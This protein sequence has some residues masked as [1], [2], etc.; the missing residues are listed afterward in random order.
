[1]RFSLSTAGY[2]YPSA[3]DRERLGKLGFK[4]QPSD[5]KGYSLSDDDE[6]QSIE[7]STLEELLAFIREHG[8]IIMTEDGIKI[9]DDYID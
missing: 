1:M 4:F 8:D 2:F 7:I 9:Y 6:T 3:S 5:Y